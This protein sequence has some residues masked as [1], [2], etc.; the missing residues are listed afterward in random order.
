MCRIAVVRLIAAAAFLFPAAAGAREYVLDYPGALALARERTPAVVAARARV[1]EARAR[2]AGASVMLPSNPELEVQAGPRLHG[3][4]R[5]TDVEV[6]L[7]QS[8]ELGGRRGA[9]LAVVDAGIEREASSADDVLR[10]VLRDVALAFYRA[11]LADERVRLATAAASAAAD[12]LTTAEK[13]LARGD[14]A[15][16]DVNL[17]RAAAARARSAVLAAEADREAAVG[18]LRALLAL[19]PGDTLVVRG[20]LSVR[21][22]HALDALLASARERPDVHVLDGE[23]GEGQAEERLGASQGW[24]DL[25]LGV[26]YAREEDADIVLGTVALTLPFF[27]RGQGERSVGRAKAARA[28]IEKAGLARAIDGEVRAAFAVYEKRRAAADEYAKNV[29]PLVEENEALLRKGFE[30]GQ[31]TLAEYLAARRE[32]L[33][34]RREHVDRRF[35]AAEAA[36]E[37]EAAAGVLK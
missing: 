22:E 13:R 23:R 27:A 9:R 24:P 12:L 31:L 4:A 15:A 1:D 11:V 20:D 36:V 18:A 3:D 30:A 37:L 34:A 5:S 17:A 21:R 8:F 10:L 33:E 6:G 16:L 2:R 32:L 19:A 7:S 26:A 28:S 25:R 35:E 14:L 29:L